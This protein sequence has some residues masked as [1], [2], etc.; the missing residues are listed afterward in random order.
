MALN[1]AFH[2]DRVDTVSLLAGSSD[3]SK[4]VSVRVFVFTC[5]I[6]LLYISPQ[7]NVESE[8]EYHM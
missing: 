5:H 1:L 3:D 6:L 7:A 4:I 2:S 8:T